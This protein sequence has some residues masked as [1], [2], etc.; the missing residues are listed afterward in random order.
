M[1]GQFFDFSWS[2]GLLEI[3]KL[4]LAL[5]GGEDY[6]A[7]ALALNA[8]L[9]T[10]LPS[11]PAEEREAAILD[12]FQMI[13]HSSLH[14]SDGYREQVGAVCA[15]VFQDIE[16]LDTEAILSMSELFQT[17]RL[18]FDLVEK[19]REAYPLAARMGDGVL[20]YLARREMLNLLMRS[21]RWTEETGLANTLVLELEGASQT[22]K[23]AAERLSGALLFY[24]PRLEAAG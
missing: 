20:A 3:T 10:E 15:I 11:L 14:N 23:A 19:L 4:N 9:K 17:Y 6:T 18:N 7:P 12:V 8:I 21:S 13:F 22:V 5:T 24:D 16:D 2:G 1:N